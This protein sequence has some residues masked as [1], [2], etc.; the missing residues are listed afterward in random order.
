M[1]GRLIPLVIGL[2]F[3]LEVAAL[4]SR[5]SHAVE[6][7]QR[8]VRLGFVSPTSLSPRAT[9]PRAAGAERQ[10]PFWIRLGELGWVEGRNLI[11]DA[12]SAEGHYD[13]LPALMTE[14]V[15]RKVDVLVTFSTPAGIA[16]KN[17]TSTVPIVDAAMFDPVRDGLV[18]SLAHPGGNLTGMSWAWSEGFGG[19]FLEL[20]QE[21]VPRLS[22]VALITNPRNPGERGVVKEVVTAAE[23]RHLKLV[24]IPLRDPDS[25]QPALQ[26][27]RRTGQALLL[28]GDPVF[29]EHRKEIIS[30]ARQYRFP[31][32]Y[33]LRDFVEAGGLMSY[34]L[35]QKAIWR[36]AAEY[37]D[38]ILRGARP[39]ELPIEQPTQYFLT[40]N[41]G[42][43]KA[44]GITIPESILLRADEVI[45]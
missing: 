1:N 13:R 39:E 9:V 17:A 26:Q 24:V 38:K 27:A 22:T 7:E 28:I 40:V 14:L 16:A 34:G 44:L 5:L 45:R 25:V 12:R 10:D 33:G 29:F 6:P 3:A 43:A 35:D 18:A 37:V 15:D 31:A 20:L 42:V 23:V 21:T 41:T 2:S 19:K 8:I 32:L 11:V 36:R 4:T 30:F